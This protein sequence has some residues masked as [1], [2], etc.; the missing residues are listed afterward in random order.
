MAS[1]ASFEDHF[2]TLA[3]AYARHR[4]QY[5]PELFDFLA[6]C[7][8]ARR[9]VWDVGTGN[10]QAAAALAERF[11]RV[12]ATDA[13]AAQIAQAAPHERVVF[14]AEPAERTSLPSAGGG[15]ATGAGGASA[16]AGV[17]LITVA[18]A[19]HWFD[20]DAFYAE[21]RRVAGP[22]AVL[23]VWCYK[24]GLIDPR[25]DELMQYFYTDVVG[26]YWSPRVRL[27][28]E[29]YRSLPFPFAEL[30]A[31]EFVAVARWRLDDL[32]GY[33]A[34]WSAVQTFAHVHRRDP[35]D[36][37]REPLAALWGDANTVREVRW[38]LGLRVGR[39]E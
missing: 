17:D 19:V 39:V 1:P 30:P 22:R 6:S 33:L 38:R 23:A 7:A 3:A 18:Q 26:S 14:A 13:S 10:G 21:V 32:L 37:I 11:E 36:L 28:D 29:N 20:L 8:P 9:L 24:G 15:G 31:P 27:A 5:P 34:T 12:L 2:S 35:R 4:P 16:A 25:I